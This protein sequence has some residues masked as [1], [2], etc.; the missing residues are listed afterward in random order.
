VT[1]PDTSPELERL[2]EYLKR[3]H[4]FDFTAYKRTILDRR[5]RKRMQAVAIKAFGDYID[6]LEVHPEEFPQLFNT[7]LINVTA[8]FRDLP[9]W[10]FL[11]AEIIPR[12]VGETSDPVRV[13]S[14][15]SAAGQ[16]AY[17]IAILLAEHL[18]VA[19]YRQ[20]VKIYATDVDEEALTQARQATYGPR[21]VEDLPP[22]YLEK[23]FERTAHHYV[24][25]KELRR[26]VI[27]GRHD[28]VQDA[29]IS[30]V[31]LLVCRNTLMY[32]NSDTRSRILAGFHYALNGTGFLFLG[33][34][35]M[36]LTHAHLFSPVDLKSRI[37]VK[38]SSAETGGRVLRPA[39]ADREEVTSHMVSDARLRDLALESDPLAQIV[40]D[41]GGVVTMI[42]ERARALFGLTP[43]DLGRPL[44]DLSVSYRPADLRSA[45]EDATTG[46][47][48]V[49]R[50]DVAWPGASGEPR[51]LDVTA[52]PLL[53]L[54]GSVLGVKIAFDDV[55]S[56]KRLQEELH[57]SKQALETAYEELQSS[58]EELETTNEELQSSNEELETTNEELQSTNEELE[59]MN[60]ELQSTNEELETINTEL[61]QR[62]DEVTEGNAFLA[63]VLAGL[64][65][66]VTVVDRELKILVWN[67]RAADL[68]GLRPDE[69]RGRHLFDLDIG[70][71]LSELRQPI[72][73]CLAG[74]SPYQQVGLDATDRRGR[75]VRC[76]V[77]C[78]PLGAVPGSG[79]R[80]VIVLMEVD[81]AATP[82]R[83]GR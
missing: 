7:I 2:L 53:D 56:Y 58:N 72:R 14:A 82:S 41:P 71:P 78:T 24:F 19:H 18:G 66:G 15:G 4:G 52:L 62:T 38:V 28:L 3:T 81:D 44:R 35:E 61:R 40:V 75:S 9:A 68:W 30:R 43:D 47:R 51:L 69:A 83:P 63:S 25:N 50:K 32:F 70:L 33:K 1:Q 17:S 31:R 16:E 54:D 37:F 11:A 80:G 13:W 12:V 67:E 26:S 77:T 27:F 79:I 76:T 55:T 20:R 60:E 36:L 48:P 45:L 10:E 29:P 57:Q 42:N 6:Y 64:R 65:T 59:T 46:R 5:I 49:V 22:R 8:F 34:A 21:E 23:Y 74:E 39:V 73:A